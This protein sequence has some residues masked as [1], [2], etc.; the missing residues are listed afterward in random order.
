[1][2]SNQEENPSSST[3]EVSNYLF[4][5][6]TAQSGGPLE[7]DHRTAQSGGHFFEEIDGEVLLRM[8]QVEFVAEWTEEQREVSSVSPEIQKAE[9]SYTKTWKGS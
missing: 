1:M 9:V 7:T 5:H 4:D 6:R 3:Q 8:A 2:S